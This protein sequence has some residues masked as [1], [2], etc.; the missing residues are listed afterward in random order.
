MNGHLPLQKLEFRHFAQ[1]K[2]VV[3]QG[4]PLVRYEHVIVCMFASVC[5]SV[6]VHA[7]VVYVSLSLR[8]LRL[9]L[10]EEPAFLPPLERLPVCL[11]EFPFSPKLLVSRHCLS[12]WIR[13][14]SNQ[15]QIAGLLGF[16]SAALVWRI[17]QCYLN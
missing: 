15:V 7:C 5:V 6:C 11:S 12:S 1:S 9:S 14:T 8:A 4:M 2:N 16:S 17:Q 3:H 10:L 13:T